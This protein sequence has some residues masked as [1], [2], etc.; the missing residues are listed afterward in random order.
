MSLIS[1]RGYSVGNVYVYVFVY[2][3][4]H[5]KLCAFYKYLE[6]FSISLHDGIMRYRLSVAQTKMLLENL[7]YP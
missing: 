5:E 2:I 1:L 7:T 4:L 6:M 3:L